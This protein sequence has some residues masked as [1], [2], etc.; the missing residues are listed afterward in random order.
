MADD[1][2]TAPDAKTLDNFLRAQGAALRANDPPPATRKEWEERRTKLRQSMFAAM[3]NYRLV[4]FFILLVAAGVLA[5]APIA[6]VFAIATFA[7]L[8]ITTRTPLTVV[9]SRIDEGMSHIILLSVPL[10]VFLG[11]LIEATGMARTMTT[12]LGIV[13]RPSRSLTSAAA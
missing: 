10:F 2:L 12:G 7:F 1:M 6:F 4:V 11:L 3:G 8:A 5:G 9:V 13:A